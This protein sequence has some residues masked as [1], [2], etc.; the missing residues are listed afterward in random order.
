[1]K[2]STKVYGLIAVI[3]AGLVVAKLVSPAFPPPDLNAPRFVLVGQV[4]RRLPEGALVQV[5]REAVLVSG[6]TGA[7]VT[8]ALRNE[9]TTRALLRGNPGEDHL[10]DGDKVDVQAVE[11]GVYQKD[12]E[13]LRAYWYV[14]VAP[15]TTPAP[16]VARPTPTPKPAPVYRNPLDA[17]AKRVGYWQH[18][19]Y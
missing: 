14:G 4:L 17:P 2:S 13:T 11:N 3:V 6:S 16:V 8:T 7:F 15:P 9:D 1:M 18:G 5:R 10:V 12:G 19:W